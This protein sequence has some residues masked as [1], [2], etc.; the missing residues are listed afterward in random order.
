M[1]SRE[2]T[3]VSSEGCWVKPAESA[4]R[5]LRY[6]YYGQVH[7]TDDL[8]AVCVQN[9]RAILISETYARAFPASK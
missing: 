8:D 5:G 9:L 1:L 6:L 4:H 3:G 2:R 7:E